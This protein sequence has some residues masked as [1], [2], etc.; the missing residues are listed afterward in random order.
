MKNNLRINKFPL[1]SKKESSNLQNQ[2]FYRIGIK[3]KNL[4]IRCTESAYNCIKKKD[5]II[6][7]TRKIMNIILQFYPRWNISSGSSAT[8]WR[9]SDARAP[10]WYHREPESSRYKV[11]PKTVCGDL[12]GPTSLSRIHTRWPDTIRPWSAVYHQQHLRTTSH[13]PTKQPTKQPLIK[14]AH[15]PD[16][17]EPNSKNTTTIP[18]TF[19][20]YE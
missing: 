8:R 7:T 3:R 9:C 19:P 1:E 6:G 2:N 16:E 17:K 20:L 12:S 14:R 13:P 15:P 18:S 10:P 5:R 11:C 4:H